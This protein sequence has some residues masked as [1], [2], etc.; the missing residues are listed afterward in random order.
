MSQEMMS[1]DQLAVFL[2]R[3]AR[4]VQ[5]WASRG[6]LPSHKVSGEYRFHPAEIN[7]WVETQM[8]AYTEQELTNL[9]Q[10]TAGR[11]QDQQPLLSTMLTESTTAVP[12]QASTKASVLKELVKLA[13]Q[14]WQVFDPEAILEAIRQREELASTG[15]ESGLAIPHPRRPLP[16]ALGEH[17][18]AFGRL[19]NPI[20]FGAPHGGL[21]DLFF[22]VC[23]R[24]DR[25]HLRTLARL[26]RLMLRPEFAA[27]LRA[28]ETP[29]AA[30][31]VIETAEQDLQQ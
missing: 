8:H 30:L 25:T 16:N 31:Q 23:C 2:H 9:E 6:Y 5:K 28:A 19:V 29:A 18:V 22:L 3:D 20:P 11:G 7:H 17:V 10:G 12:L 21:T 15:L 14:S 4:E 13:E 1:V 24:D 27:D 26:S